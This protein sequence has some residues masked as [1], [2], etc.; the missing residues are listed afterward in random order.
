MRTPEPQHFSVI[1]FSENSAGKP[2][3]RAYPENEEKMKHSREN[4]QDSDILLG[5]KSG[6]PVAAR[7]F[8]DRFAVRINRLVWRL[9]GADSEHDDVV[10]E[11]FANAFSCIDQVRDSSRLE[12]WVVGVTV[13]TV[14]RELRRRRFRRLFLVFGLEEDP[15]ARELDP[16]RQALAHQ[17]YEMLGHVHPEERIVFILCMVEGFSQP[18]AARAC[19]ISLSTCKRRLSRAVARVARLAGDWPAARSILDGNLE[20]GQEDIP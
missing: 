18:E 4:W 9:L 1:A 8:F 15:P 2:Q 11:V 17:F 20:E 13:N 14:R 3:G 16:E 12:N 19:G 10:Q 7:A 6:D 5:V